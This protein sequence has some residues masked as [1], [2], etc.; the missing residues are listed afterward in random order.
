MCKAWTLISTNRPNSLYCSCT[1]PSEADKRRE[2]PNRIFW[3]QSRILFWNSKIFANQKIFK[4]SHFQFRFIKTGDIGLTSRLTLRIENQD[5]QNLLWISWERV[6]FHLL[7]ETLWSWIL[8]LPFQYLQSQTQ[9]IL[10]WSEVLKFVR[11]SFKQ[12]EEFL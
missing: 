3:I 12:R 10:V 4:Y 5:L 7:K 2:T 6:P 9:K 11:I 8:F 1:L